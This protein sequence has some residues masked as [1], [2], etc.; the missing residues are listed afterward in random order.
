MPSQT[1]AP[2]DVMS[3]NP[4][5]GVTFAPNIHSLIECTENRGRGDI[6]SEYDEGELVGMGVIDSASIS[7][8]RSPAPDKESQRN[9]RMGWARQYHGKPITAEF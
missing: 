5:P 7:S 3:G 4:S 8:A 2:H 9:Q 1:V 6:P